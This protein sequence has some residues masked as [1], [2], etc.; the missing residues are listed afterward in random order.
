MC[1][2]DHDNRR[3]RRRRRHVTAGEDR[4][5]DR[6]E[7]GGAD[8]VHLWPGAAELPQLRPPLA[9]STAALALRMAM[10]SE[11][12]RVRAAL[13]TD[14]HSSRSRSVSACFVCCGASEGFQGMSLAG[15]GLEAV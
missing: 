13:A 9:R 10:A 8:H 6:G 11:S 3:A 2:S 15:E 5:A 14:A 7:D 1:R 12:P 4:G